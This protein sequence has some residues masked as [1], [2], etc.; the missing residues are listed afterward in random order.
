LCNIEGGL[1]ARPHI[2]LAIMTLATADD[3]DLEP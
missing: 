1:M 2:G 3:R